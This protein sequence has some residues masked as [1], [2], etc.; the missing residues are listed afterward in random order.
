MEVTIHSDKTNL[1]VSGDDID[2]ITVDTICVN[3]N[4]IMVDVSEAYR[5]AEIIGYDMSDISDGERSAAEEMQALKKKLDNM[6]RIISEAYVIIEYEYNE[7][8]QTGKI[9]V[10]YRLGEWMT[11]AKV[12]LFDL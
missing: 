7:A 8:D 2:Y 5:V 1:K 10:A 6:Q 3:G 4:D 11:D 9:G 12:A